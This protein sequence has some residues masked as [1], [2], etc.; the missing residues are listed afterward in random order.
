MLFF[1]VGLLIAGLGVPLWLRRVPPNRFYGVR[2]EAT[3]ADEARWYSV[4][5][6]TGRTMVGVGMSTAILSI[7]LDGFGIVGDA[8][9]LTMAVVLIAGGALVTFVGFRRAP[10]HRGRR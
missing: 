2:T 6:S 5:A 4:N 3:R 10:E 7:A 8:H 1:L 9:A